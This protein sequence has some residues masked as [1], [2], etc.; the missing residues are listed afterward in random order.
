MSYL[1]TSVSVLK[2]YSGDFS[3]GDTV[4][5]LTLVL[6]DPPCG[7]GVDEAKVRLLIHQT[8]SPF[9]L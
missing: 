5:A 6:E 3:R 9:Q 8:P 1:V 7:P 4:G 2:N